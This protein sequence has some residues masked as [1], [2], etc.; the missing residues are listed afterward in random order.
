MAS[1]PVMKPAAF[2]PPD[3][4]VF[5]DRLMSLTLRHDFYDGDLFEDFT[6]V[7]TI[8][9]LTL[10]HNLGLIARLRPAGIDILYHT[11][12]SAAILRYLYNRRDRR[13]AEKRP[14]LD[15]SAD[16]NKPSTY[17]GCWSRLTLALFLQNS[18]FSNFTALPLAEKPDEKRPGEMTPGKQA[19]YLS[20]RYAE[21]ADDQPPRLIA[22]RSSRVVS[23]PTTTTSPVHLH[24]EAPPKA[25]EF[26]L[27]DTSGRAILRADKDHPPKD[28]PPKDH[29]PKDH[30]PKGYSDAQKSSEMPP[31]AHY[32]GAGATMH[33]SMANEWPG[34]FSY[35][36]KNKD[37]NN[38]DRVLKSEDFI[39]AGRRRP[40]L[41][42]VDLFLASP[43]EPATPRGC[44]PVVVP[45]ELPKELADKP[46]KVAR[47][48]SNAAAADAAA[49]KYITPRDYELRFGARETIW[50][51]YIVLPPGEAAP[52]DLAIRSEPRDNLAEPQDSLEFNGP[53]KVTLPT[54]V[55]ACCFTAKT[56]A[57]LRRRSDIVLRLQS[58][59]PG[60]GSTR[61][62]LKRLPTPS[63][64]QV[65]V[66]PRS[67]DGTATSEIFV[68]L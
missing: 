3:T 47:V 30:P 66:R 18:L 43:D 21:Q 56:P 15:V 14:D 58:G 61:T 53:E 42:F 37:D 45:A 49:Q 41:M 12:R 59:G 6:I 38:K 67:T 13:P 46:D 52:K 32:S 57:P 48:A 62:L 27:Y 24:F 22:D 1:D 60:N 17:G 36:F 20:N 40:P 63:A 26:I 4:Q 34:L 51:Y 65:S 25:T 31:R 5:Y 29:P 7:P 23:I 28:H 2:R 19:L 50:T 35:V 8:P 68:Y 64:E 16:Y 54:G 9:T 39:Y 33:V 44:Y 10:L 11:G 55:S